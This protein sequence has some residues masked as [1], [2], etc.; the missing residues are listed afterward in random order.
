M[1]SLNTLSLSSNII[2]LKIL[3]EPIWACLRGF[4]STNSNLRSVTESPKNSERGHVKQLLVRLHHA[5]NQPKNLHWFHK[6]KIYL[7]F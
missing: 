4:M 1:I 2:S 3:E 7:C 6:R 5:K